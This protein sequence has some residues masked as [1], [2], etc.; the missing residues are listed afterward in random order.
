MKFSYKWLKQL[1]EFDKN[2]QELADDLS[3]R[4]IEIESIERFGGKFLEKVVVGEIKEITPHPDAD[5]L[6]VTKTDIGDGGILQIVCGAP[7]IEVGQKVPVSLV[8][9]V[10]PAGEIKE[11]K[12]RGVESCGMLC[13]E[14]ELGFGTDHSGIM[15][16]DEKLSIGTKLSDIYSDWI[17]DGAILA[18]RGDLQNHAGL[19]LEIAAIYGTNIKEEAELIADG[20]DL[21]ND[22]VEVKNEV[23][24][25]YYSARMLKDIR[26]APSPYWMQQ[27]LMACGMRPI[28]NVVDVTNY[29]MLKYGNPLHA[30]DAKKI[31]EVNGKHQ[32][33]VRLTGDGEIIRTLD[34]QDHELG[35]GI[36][37]IAD[38][39][40]PIA[41]AGVMGG[42]NSEID[43]DTKDIILESA[44]FDQKLIRKS[45]RELGIRTEASA[46]FEKG[47][48]N[49]LAKVCL[50]EAAR[51]FVDVCGGKLVEGK[52]VSGNIQEKHPK[53]ICNLNRLKEYLSMDIS[54][55]EIARILDDLGI[56]N[57]ISGEIIFCTS[58]EWRRDIKIWQDIA[59]EIGRIYSLDRV[60][61]RELKTAIKPKT[62]KI[63][64]FDQS[65]RRFLSNSGLSEIFSMAIISDS[66]TKDTGFSKRYFELDNPLN[67]D[68]RVMRASL[69]PGL[70]GYAAENAKREDTFGIFD[71]SKVY[72][73]SENIDIPSSEQRNLA[74]LVYGEKEKEGFY[75]A[76]E[77]LENFG[78]AFDLEFSF[79]NI[80]MGLM[81]EKRSYCH[82][83]R[84]ASI[85]FKNE[86]IGEIFEIHPMVLE[87]VGLKKKAWALEINFEKISDSAKNVDLKFGKHDSGVIFVPYSKFEVSKRD[88]AIILSKDL[89]PTEII[90]AVLETDPMVVSAEIFDEYIS[91]KFG[92]GKK[93]IAIHLKFQSSQKTLEDKEVDELFKK[94]LNA[95]NFKF[96]AEL[97]G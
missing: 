48:P 84:C 24:G 51:L 67:E 49:Y 65:A 17:L 36:L 4:S 59:E 31:P 82:P 66:L 37:V 96:G 34:G 64:Y 50:D 13:A 92:E 55:Q 39:D 56:E 80:G 10:L 69:L 25:T 23:P 89:E 38:K 88:M 35:A 22:I 78:R 44:V 9:C 27:S 15:I 18:N 12:I 26:I 86:K 83:G 16:L 79:E 33:I 72:L 94:V 61:E 52:V 29:V 73:P 42:E 57:E 43:T 1:V 45:Q 11:A 62:K 53:I 47:L 54:N 81:E 19:A 40:R 75:I 5:K 71:I 63:I 97:R 41:V 70:I 58:P 2:P 30:F 20:A 60:I 28:N 46:R 85:L 90:K 76:K 21:V 91:D 93:S 32:I 95:L 87:N 6:R 3:C 68:D 74:I 77:Y 14:D 7:N 8:G